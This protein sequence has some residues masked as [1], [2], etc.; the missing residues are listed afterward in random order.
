MMK[1]TDTIKR[2]YIQ[3]KS[4]YFERSFEEKYPR[5]TLYVFQHSALE[6]KHLGA[7]L[8]KIGIE[9]RQLS[10][11]RDLVCFSIVAILNI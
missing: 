9:I 4:G 5:K 7:N 3:G 11:F 2:V 8:I 10:E 1:C 6:I